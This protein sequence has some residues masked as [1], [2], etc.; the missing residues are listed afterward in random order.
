MTK[1]A[2]LTTPTSFPA[3]GGDLKNLLLAEHEI[4]QARREAAALVGHDLTARQLNDLELLLTGGFSP[5]TGFLNEGDYQ[6]VVRELRLADG[7]LWPMP[8]VLDV[9]TAF[10]GRVA[11]G[12][13]IA[14]KDVEGAPLAIL[15]IESIYTP[16]RH[17]EAQAVFGTS[18]VTHPGVAALVGHTQ[19][20]YLGGRVRGI[21]L[22]RHFD[23]RGD[24]HTPATLRSWFAA[25][26]WTRI[27]AFQTR[28]PL[29]R[30]HFE[31]TQRA[32]QSVDAK[33][34]LHPVVGQTK[35]GDIDHFTRVRCYQAVLPHYTPGNAKLSLLPLAMRMAGPREALWHA[36]IRKN[37]GATHFII[38]RD[39]AG[40]G[41]DKSGKPFY[42]PLAAQELVQQHATELGIQIVAFPAYVYSAKRQAYLPA[43]EAQA[44]DQI[45]D[46]SGTELRQR[47]SSGAEIPAWFSFP[48]V[49]QVLRERHPGVAAK[50]AVVLFTGLSGSGKS[51]LAN[52]LISLILER[53]ARPVTLLDGDVVRKHL[54]KG[55][56]FS[57][58]DRDANV[59]RIGFVASEVARH[60]GIAVCA[61]IAPFAAARAEVRK[62]TLDA[63][64]EFVEVHVSTSLEA[65]EARDRK[66][67]YAKAR[68]GEIQQFTGIS[69]PYEVPES[70]AL[71]V[72]GASGEPADL[73]RQV[74]ELLIARGVV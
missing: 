19:P 54:S 56:G 24:R 1:T 23:F 29:H 30:A 46:I 2:T 21:E 18:D 50:G 63:G 45:T 7:T 34:L 68:S 65:C 70:P 36:I 69:D 31:L 41:N 27:V 28:N 11:V 57:R 71:R 39:H 47:L 43:P 49:V 60:N 26:G 66:G 59:T 55:L 73:A 72:D 12:Q 6:R 52:A 22:P 64:G 14:L 51:T 40:P 32:A 42:A 74:L 53:S 4:A 37:Y 33:L 35:P 3:H 67:L 58:E 9:S 17:A 10:A 48:D 44:D 61:P 25:N 5:L 38:G 16:D 62:L 15:D 13:S 20:V 8:I